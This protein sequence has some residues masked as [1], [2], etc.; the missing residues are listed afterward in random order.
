MVENLKIWNLNKLENDFNSIIFNSIIEQ[1]KVRRLIYKAI[2]SN[3][4]THGFIFSG[5]VGTG[6]MAMALE[7]ARV[8]NCENDPSHSAQDK[9][10]C[11]SCRLITNINHPNLTFIFPRAKELDKKKNDIDTVMS[12]NL[13]RLRVNKY[14]PF[15]TSKTG[16]VRVEQ[17]RELRRSMSLS[18]DRTGVRVAIIKPAENMNAN[19]SNALL[20]LLEEPP[21]KCC[22][23]LISSGA[24]LMLP[25]I[26]S[27]CQ[28]L[29]FSPISSQA[30]VNNLVKNH[31]IPESDATL[32]ADLSDGGLST[33]KSMLNED[34]QSMI[35]DSLEFLRASVQG[36]AVKIST[37]V[38]KWS[39]AGVKDKILKNLD[40]I[41]V[42]VREALFIKSSENTNVGN[43]SNTVNDRSIVS[44]KLAVKYTYNQLSKTWSE[45]ETARQSIKS[46]GMPQLVFTALA[47]KIGRVM[48]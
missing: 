18:A 36:Q 8:L 29:N 40:Y 21:D 28:L 39:K 35:K 26:M 32:I 12:E 11:V 10:T 30:I 47:L 31:G 1:E 17:I 9:C 14:A 3:R 22:I 46:N 23:I 7:L 4:L 20:K 25:T 16:V 44:A 48:K 38:D 42:W 41:S 13:E 24:R 2:K 43:L 34:Y 19:A 45:I 6:R 37:I 5:P 27:R 33:A 15:E